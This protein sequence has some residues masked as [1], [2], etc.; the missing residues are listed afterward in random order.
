[1]YNINESVETI[2]FYLACMSRKQRHVPLPCFAL[3]Y[4]GNETL[5]NA[6]YGAIF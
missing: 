4:T 1:M 3:T 2:N 5:R 6:L